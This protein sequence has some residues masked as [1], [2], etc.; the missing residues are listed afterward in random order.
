ML[1]DEQERLLR[2]TQQNL[3]RARVIDQVYRIVIDAAHALIPDAVISVVR[4]DRASKGMQFLAFE[5]LGIDLQKISAIFGF[6]PTKRITK[7][8]SLSPAEFAMYGNRSLSLIPDGIH[9]LMPEAAPNAVCDIVQGLMRVKEVYS[10][11]FVLEERSLGGL[12]ILARSDIQGKQ[13]LIEL[14]VNQAA[15]VVQRMFIEEDLKESRER[16]DSALY[17][18]DEGLW[19]WDISRNQVYFDERYYS[20]A[21]YETG[22]FP[23]DFGEWEKRVHP[24]DLPGSKA[25][26]QAYFEGKRPVFN[27][28]FRFLRK[29]GSWMFIRARGKIIKRDETGQ[30]LRMIGTHTDISERK[31][32]EEENKHLQDQLYQAQKMESVGRLAGG[33]AHD[34][35]N[36]LSA[37][38][39]YSEI[40]MATLEEGHPARDHLAEIRRAGERS[41]DLTR[42]LLAF[43]RKQD[44]VPKILD[45]N[46]SIESILKMLRRLIG[47][48]VRLEWLPQQGMRPVK[49]DPSQVDQIL[50]N[51]CVNARD[52]IK[53]KGQIR[54]TT[55]RLRYDDSYAA[56]HPGSKAGEF[57]CVSVSDDGCGMGTEL[58]AHLFEPFFTTKE[59]GKGTGLGL[60]TI[61][62]IVKQNEGFIEV[63]SETGRGSTFRVCLPFAPIFDSLAVDD[64]EA[65]RAEPGNEAI[66]IVEDE[67]MI[68]EMS[69]IT[70]R[71]KGYRVF[72]TS[73]P[74][75]ACDLARVNHIDLL[76]TDI[77]MPRMNGQDLAARVLALRTGVKIL[78]M[79][80]YTA[81]TFSQQDILTKGHFFIQ[82]PFSPEEL[83]RKIRRILDSVRD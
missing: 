27:M 31:R 26:I 35:N 46:Q 47:E 48:D 11:G 62:G 59:Q 65:P 55:S 41:A 81:D 53:D 2:D 64:L 83:A 29:D 40:A 50:A 17:V 67:A 4:L 43:A 22:D 33:V 34:F 1:S 74:D 77:I 25:E 52:A 68:L 66:L 79:S 39:G 80:G 21:G 37:I 72:A 15:F 60:A 45:L 42:Q 10:I 14:I 3:I 69:S 56:N 51:L 38:L 36:M 82:K 78:Y 49:M 58:M 20:M 44:I 18:S 75:E 7:L 9:G 19:D 6:D 73:D 5:G 71:S 8:E 16:L 32:S 57:A 23:M 12:F 13:S 63:E 30:P 54:I 28:E 70:L 24:D 76:L 61:Y